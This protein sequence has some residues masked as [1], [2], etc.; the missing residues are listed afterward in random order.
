MAMT[1]VDIWILQVV[2]ER[3]K[4]APGGLGNIHYGRRQ[5]VGP[6]FLSNLPESLPSHGRSEQGSQSESKLRSARD[7][8]MKMACAL[9]K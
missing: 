6:W 4:S 1:D 2:R 9:E 7:R 3:G 5:T 8:K